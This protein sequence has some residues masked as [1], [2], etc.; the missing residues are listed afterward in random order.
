MAASMILIR[1]PP[2]RRIGH[3]A[4]RACAYAGARSLSKP[5]QSMPISVD[6]TPKRS[7]SWPIIVNR[8]SGTARWIIGQ[9][10]LVSHKIASRFGGYAAVPTNT[11][12]ADR[13]AS[14]VPKEEAV[15][16]T[17]AI[18]APRQTLP[19]LERSSSELASKHVAIL[20]TWR[21]ACRARNDSARA[22]HFAEG[23]FTDI[24]S[25]SSLTCSISSTSTTSGGSAVLARS[26]G[27]AEP[28][29]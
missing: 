22:R 16:G 9:I 14:D 23:L 26:K 27:T 25:L 19:S 4:N 13:A 28:S 3:T 2:L 8:A 11:A 20:P 21:S 29:R 5:W 18:F 1:V 6:S 12:I 15:L 17:R 7:V 24:A 10:S